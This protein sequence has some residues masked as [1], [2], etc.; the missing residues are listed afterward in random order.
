VVLLTMQSS[1]SYAA[2]LSLNN[3]SFY[4]P[5]EENVTGNALD[6]AYLMQLEYWKAKVSYETANS[7][8]EK[9]LKDKDEQIWRDFWIQLALTGCLAYSLNQSL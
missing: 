7:V 3:F 1:V 8:T 2:A 9:L 4:K 5:K 6:Q